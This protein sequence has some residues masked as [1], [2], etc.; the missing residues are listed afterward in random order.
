MLHRSLKNLAFSIYV[1]IFPSP[2]RRSTDIPEH[3]RCRWGG[4]KPVASCSQKKQIIKQFS[5]LHLLIQS[6]K[7][8]HKK[9]THHEVVRS[10]CRRPLALCSPRRSNTPPRGFTSPRRRRRR[11]RSLAR[12]ARKE[13]HRRHR[14]RRRAQIPQMSPH[15][16]R[17]CRPVFEGD[18][19]H[20]GVLYYC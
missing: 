19:H 11:R 8:F 13:S 5:N 2:K 4:I 12:A 15:L 14:R 18:P 1:C 3:G 16:V 7:K 9:L 6:Q 17:C 10:H 20:Y